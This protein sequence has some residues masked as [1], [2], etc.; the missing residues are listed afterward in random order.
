[1]YGN[2]GAGATCPKGMMEEEA[3]PLSALATTSAVQSAG[4]PT[5][6]SHTPR[7]SV[8]QYQVSL[9]GDAKS[10]LG[11][12]ESSLGDAKSSLSVAKRARWVTLRVR[13][14]TLR[15]RWVTLR[16]P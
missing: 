8:S 16:A 2:A 10:S 7:P 5:Y 13:W 6:A 11:G 1:V 14:V 3:V 4:L 12:A 9:L 15:A